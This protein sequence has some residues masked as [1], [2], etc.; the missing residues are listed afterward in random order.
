MGEVTREA[1]RN[2]GKERDKKET[3]RRG[4][5][6]K[7]KRDHMYTYKDWHK[8][9]L[10]YKPYHLKSCATINA[11]LYHETFHLPVLSRGRMLSPIQHERERVSIHS[12]LE[13]VAWR[14]WAFCGRDSVM[15]FNLT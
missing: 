1:K 7:C 8:S 11:K 12:C 6:N 5:T 2:Q 3:D 15:N 10:I 9:L 13:E 4:K 14:N